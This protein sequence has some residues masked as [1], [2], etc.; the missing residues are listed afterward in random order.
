MIYIAI[1]IGYCIIGCIKDRKKLQELIKQDGAWMAT[2]AFAL[3]IA[4]W[5]AF[6]I[7]DIIKLFF[8]DKEK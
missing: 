8:G 6:V 3:V 5:P 4:G 7:R 2:A 1:G